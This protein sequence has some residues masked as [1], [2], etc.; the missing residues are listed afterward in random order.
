VVARSI[1]GQ[2]K[3]QGENYVFLDISHKPIQTDDVGHVVL[4]ARL[5]HSSSMVM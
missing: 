1:D 5:L 4:P 2:M 3:R